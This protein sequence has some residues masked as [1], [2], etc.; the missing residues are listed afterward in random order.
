MSLQLI[1][2]KMFRVFF[3]KKKKKKKKK[4]N[5]KFNTFIYFLYIIIALL[6]NSCS[7]EDGVG[8]GKKFLEL[9]G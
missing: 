1:I 4:Q 7:D 3:K 8:K 6:I 9:I 5:C 2:I